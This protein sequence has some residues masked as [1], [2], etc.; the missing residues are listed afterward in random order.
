MPHDHRMRP[1][2]GNTNP[3]P[4]LEALLVRKADEGQSSPF[5]DYVAANG[6]AQNA[7]N[8]YRMYRD[9][10]QGKIPRSSYFFGMSGMA[11]T[12]LEGTLSPATDRNPLPDVAKTV[13]NVFKERHQ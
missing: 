11:R 2:Y 7:L 13:G 6:G 12:R 4:R 10:A 9:Q 8:N 1:L 5:L 3:T